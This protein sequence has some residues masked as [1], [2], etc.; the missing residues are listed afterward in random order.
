MTRVS[1]E[2]RFEIDAGHRV[3]NHESVCAHP[4]GHRYGIVVR[5][6]AASGLD[7]LGRVIDFG[8]VK[9]LLGSWLDQ[10]W[11]HSF[12]VAHDDQVIRTFL[13]AN[14]FRHYLMNSNP[15][16]ENLAQHLLVDVCPNLFCGTRV[17]ITEVRI[18]ETPNC[19]A[20]AT[21]QSI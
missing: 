13:E 17:S 2:R 7:E 15:T 19:V 8:V 3:L 20:T 18:H 6:E 9:E 11:D 5:A 16:A 21:R 1:I 4:H 10:N 14:G 12:L